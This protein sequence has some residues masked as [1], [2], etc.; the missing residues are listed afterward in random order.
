MVRNSGR[1]AVLVVCSLCMCGC[2]A[3]S[4][5]VAWQRAMFPRTRWIEVSVGRASEVVGADEVDPIGPPVV[6]DAPAKVRTIAAALSLLREAPLPSMML[7]PAGEGTAYLWLQLG[8]GSW[9]FGQPF[10]ELRVDPYCLPVVLLL[11]RGARGVSFSGPTSAW[12]PALI[13]EIEAAG[14][15]TL[16]RFTPRG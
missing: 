5:S 2:R 15:V 13:S 7:C 4:T 6:I 3:A 10:A 12:D 16:P 14:H 1:V 8:T 11:R 9:P